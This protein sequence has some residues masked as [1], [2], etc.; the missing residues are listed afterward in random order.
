[1]SSIRYSPEAVNDLE[2]IWEGVLEVSGSFDTAD[3]YIQGIRDEIRKRK[4]YPQSGKRLHYDGEFS[5]I[6]YVTYKEY[7]VFYR[8]RE[9]VIEVGRVLYG[10]SDYIRTLF[11]KSEF[12]PEDTEEL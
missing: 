8:V 12:V 4:L 9:D 5:G 10:G 6:Y 2:I 11:G 3:A 1:M 7:H